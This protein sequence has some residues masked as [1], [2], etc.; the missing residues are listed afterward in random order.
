MNIIDE[1]TY[2]FGLGRDVI[3]HDGAE[4]LFSNELVAFIEREG[5]LAIQAL[6][7]AWLGVGED[8]DVMGEAARW[9]GRMEHDVTH[10]AR[11]HLLRIWLLAESHY[12]RDG[13][14]LGLASLDDPAA[15]PM[16]R[17]ALT[18]ESIPDLANAMQQVID[19]LEETE[20]ARNVE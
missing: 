5:V 18:L 9:I 8:Y 1:A 13:A 14:L 20:R 17:Y 16:L 7:Q 2:I 19:Q 15:L 10:K 11:L 12:T 3:F 6:C 4:T